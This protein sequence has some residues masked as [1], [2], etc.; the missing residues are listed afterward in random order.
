MTLLISEKTEKDNLKRADSLRD[1]ISIFESSRD[2]RTQQMRSAGVPVSSSA[3][4]TA[5]VIN[6][7]SPGAQ[8]K[9]EKTVDSNIFSHCDC[10]FTLHV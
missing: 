5:N 1:R 6:Q 2:S 10:I 9:G 3:A 7:R 8:V 4:A